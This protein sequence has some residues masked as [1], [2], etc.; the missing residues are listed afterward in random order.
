MP[1]KVLSDYVYDI[2][3]LNERHT[4]KTFLIRIYNEM[5]AEETI[6]FINDTFHFDYADY[7]PR[8]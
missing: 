4:E 5:Q 6:E 2:Y 1:D 3:L 8:F 7:N